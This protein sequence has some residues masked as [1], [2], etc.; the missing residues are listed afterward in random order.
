MPCHSRENLLLC[1]LEKAEASHCYDQKKS[2]N[3]ASRQ[4][5]SSHYRTSVLTLLDNPEDFLRR[6]DELNDI[7]V[8]LLDE[9]LVDEVGRNP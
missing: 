3:I 6:I 4:E 5:P 9:C 8:L 2:K 7:Q 1:A